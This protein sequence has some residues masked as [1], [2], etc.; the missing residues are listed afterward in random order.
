MKARKLFENTSNIIVKS[1]LTVKAPPDSY[2][3][4]LIANGRRTSKGK[5]LNKL[6]PD[7]ISRKLNNLALFT[8]KCRY[9]MIPST[10]KG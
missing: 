3:T 1:Q 7:L 10:G 5:K 8:G 6:R 9:G 2:K 4:D